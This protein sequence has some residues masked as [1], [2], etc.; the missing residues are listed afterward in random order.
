MPTFLPTTTS[1]TSSTIIPPKKEKDIFDDNSDE[2]DD[3]FK[4]PKPKNIPPSKPVTKTDPTQKIQP[5]VIRKPPIPSGESDEDDIFQTIKKTPPKPI[6]PPST[7]SAITKPKSPSSEDDLFIAKPLSTAAAKISDDDDPL[8]VDKPSVQQPAALVIPPPATKLPVKKSAPL[9]DD[10]SEDEMF[11]LTKNKSKG[12]IAE[13][14]KVVPSTKPDVQDASFS[15]PT[16]KPIIPTTETKTIIPPVKSFDDDDEDELFK[17]S[18]NKSKVQTTK[19]QKPDTT[20][21]SEPLKVNLPP[22]PTLLS[23]PSAPTDKTDFGGDPLGLAPPVKTTSQSPIAKPVKPASV[24]T[25]QPKKS[26]LSDSDENE[27]SSQNKIN[28]EALKDGEKRGVK[29][30]AVRSIHF[31]KRILFIIFS[32]LVKVKYCPKCFWTTRCT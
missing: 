18:T 16:A 30:I 15:I 24:P 27:D 17:S 8:F 25:I 11:G 2:E 7:T 4:P 3:P 10:D 6:A 31:Q 5:P 21:D 22:P 19:I 26:S 9:S 1:S 14:P 12:P 29:D 13:Q 28:P 32:P 23:F 20:I